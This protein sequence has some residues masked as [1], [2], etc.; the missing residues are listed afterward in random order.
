MRAMNRII[1]GSSLGILTLAAA[2]SAASAQSSSAPYTKANRYDAGGRLLGT[3]S[4]PPTSTGTVN[5]LVTR[6]TYDANGRLYTVETGVL[7]SWQGDAILPVAW[8]GFSL[9]T[10]TTYFYDTSG[11][12]VRESIAGSDLV[13]TGVTQYS[14]D[15]FDRLICT[16]VRMDPAQWNAQTDACIPQTNGPHGADRV[17][18]TTYDNQNRP[19]VVQ[20]AYG[21]T[22]Q[23]DYATYTYSA[24]GKQTSITDANG[25]KAVYGYDVFDRQVLWYF[26]SKTTPG[27]A[28]ATDYEQY[29]Y[30]ANGNRE[31]LRKRDGRTINYSYDPLNRMTS[32]TFVGAGACVSA[33]SS[34]PPYA[35]TTPPSW[36]ARNVYYSYDLQGLQ[37]FARFD[38]T[39]GNDR[40]ANEYDGYGGL[41]SS[42]VTMGGV[43]RRVGRSYDANGN[44]ISVTHPDTSYFSYDYD[45]LDRMSIIRQNG[46]IQVGAY[47]YDAKGRNWHAARGAVLTTLGYDNASRL[48]SI[49]DDLAGTGA[50]V[51]SS[52]GYNSAR[53]LISVGRTND[54]YAFA[55]YVQEA[56]GYTVNG[57]NQYT[58]VNG[59]PLGYDSNGNLA[60]NG[61]ASFTY[62]VENRLISAAGSLATT[63]TYDPLGRLFQTSSSTGTRQFLYDGDERIAEY[64]GGSG[65]VLRRY[66]HGAGDDDPQLWYEGSGLADRRSLQSNHQGSI[67]S[68]ADASGAVL[69]I[70]AYDEYGVPSGGDVG[71]FQYTGQAWL[72]D[73]GM[74]YYK[75]RIYSAKL[76]RFLQTDPVGY[77]DQIN[78][79]SYVSSDPINRTDPSGNQT[80]MGPV[81]DGLDRATASTQCEGDPE[82]GLKE[83][84]NI[85]EGVAENLAEAALWDLAGLAVFKGASLVWN[86]YKGLKAAPAVVKVS[87]VAHPES[88]AHIERAQAAGK[89]STLTVDRA[90]AAARR[91]EALKGTPTR[92]GT[93]RDE[94]PPA[95]FSEGGKGS[96]KEYVHPSDNR[97]S[98]ASI[99]RQCRRLKNGDNVVIVVCD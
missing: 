74:Y 60:S 21:T 26:P 44:R 87:R 56:K 59:L 76:A 85:Q 22:L 16:A 35:C 19:L 91:R 50:D 68:S 20:R 77:T 36:A 81:Y 92:K 24:T 83:W 38:S 71:P 79:Y 25:N 45:G 52:F 27:T 6:N 39:S 86:A 95:M 61:G 43:S 17:T 5:F 54:S 93:D 41:T 7:A 64:D 66:V 46:T 55:A 97:G 31:T 47:D 34:D 29:G 10:I 67:V 11:R 57:L 4:A 96:S 98:G 40:V 84:N 3:I 42:T 80:V 53:Q 58:A 75:A 14:Y 1:A 32:K 8:S 90:G 78:L 94:Y 13:V 30:D 18:R 37:T 63:M 65:A 72:P 82:C 12:K 28:S 33:P 88:A 2:A 48:T 70:K 15:A 23:Q 99:G 89:P 73:L 49:V 62:D 51:T 69:A 9:N